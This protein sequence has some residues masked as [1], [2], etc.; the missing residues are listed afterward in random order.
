MGRKG[1]LKG[2]NVSPTR[3]VKKKKAQSFVARG[4]VVE[5]GKEAFRRR[6]SSS[7]E[8]E[9]FSREKKKRRQHREEGENT[10][11]S[12]V[13]PRTGRRREDQRTVNQTRLRKRRTYRKKGGKDV[14]RH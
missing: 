12:Y 5:G 7:G 13:I 11:P 3:R 14:E 6:E 10:E 9:N 2:E 4:S 8:R 1:G